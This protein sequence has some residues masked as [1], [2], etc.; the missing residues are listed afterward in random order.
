[1]STWLYISRKRVRAAAC[2]LNPFPFVFTTI[3]ADGARALFL[4]FPC[5][6]DTES[7]WVPVLLFSLMVWVCL[8]WYVSVNPGSLVWGEP[9]FTS[10]V[11]RSAP[12]ELKWV[13][14]K[15]I[16]ILLPRF[17]FYSN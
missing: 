4:L 5:R 6:V 1:M 12:V 2:A 3:V 15:Y 8:N 9:Q 14:S 16:H 11:K 13:L 17:S 7:D 10:P